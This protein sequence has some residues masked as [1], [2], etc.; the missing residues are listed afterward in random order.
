MVEKT[1]RQQ[2][3]ARRDVLVDSVIEKGK[4]VPVGTIRPR[5]N[6]NWIKTPQGWKYHSLK[7]KATPRE[8]DPEKIAGTKLASKL[9]TLVNKVN[10]AKTFG[11]QMSLIT[12]AGI[13]DPEKVVELTNADL[14]H[15]MK[16]MSAKGIEPVKQDFNIQDELAKLESMEVKKKMPKVPVKQRWE[17]YRMF[18][19]MVAEGLA[20][21]AIAY[22][23]GGVGKTYNLKQSF[24]G[25]GLREFGPGEIVGSDNYDYVKITGKSTPTAMYKA[26]YEHNGKI[27]VFDDCDSVLKDETSI[28]ILKGALDTTGDGTIS[29]AS[30]KRIKGTE[31]AEIPQRFQFDGRA[32]FV[33]NLTPS[34]MP[35]PLRSRALTID[36]TMTASETIEI[37]RTFIDKMPFQDNKGRVI[38]VS[39]ENRKAAIDFMAKYQNDLDIGDINARTLGQVALIKKKS[40]QAGKSNWENV[41][42]AMFS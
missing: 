36:L 6:Q 32:V 2:Q 39:Q 16:Y 25:H 19:D 20:K 3:Q 22:G 4:A 33:S 21:S 14:S 1:I 11:E 23:T 30:G 5:G 17:A 9:F 12:S 8:S 15:V 24:D 18:L 42:L 38:D 29:Y 27:V 31:G 10:A 13:A 26:L 34:E 40:E 35:Q 7:H 41:A 28:N 37:M